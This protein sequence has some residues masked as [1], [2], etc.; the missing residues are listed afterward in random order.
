MNQATGNGSRRPVGRVL[1]GASAALLFVAAIIQSEVANADHGDGGGGGFHDRGGGFHG[2]GSTIALGISAPCSGSEAYTHRFR[3]VMAIPSIPSIPSTTT[4][5][6]ATIPTIGISA[7][8][9]APTI[10]A[11]IPTLAT[12]RS[13]TPDRPGTIAPTPLA[14]IHLSCVR[15]VQQF[16]RGVG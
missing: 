6:T 11:T 2:G 15:Q 13:P 8:I 4:G 3:G 5:I 9:P 1:G 14:I 7:M 16:D 10:T 12:A